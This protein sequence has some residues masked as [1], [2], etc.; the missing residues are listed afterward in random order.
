M[1][2]GKSGRPKKAVKRDA[3]TGV[4]FTRAEY[5]IVKQ[6]A[7]KAN[8]KI[9]VYVRSMSLEGYVKARSRP[10]DKQLEKQL[11]GMANNINQ[12][13]KL[14]HQKGLLTALLFF[15]KIRVELDEILNR[16][17]DDQ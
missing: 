7:L 15:E 10:A 1:A 16:L 3:A 8:M 6:K 12:M 4:R 17:R 5:F 14:A 11:A 2:N 9:T 13:T